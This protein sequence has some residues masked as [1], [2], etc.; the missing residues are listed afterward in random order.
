VKNVVA[1]LRS[2]DFFAGGSILEV[3]A[4]TGH[5]LM[6]G[7]P[8]RADVFFDSSPV[9][10]PQDGFQGTVVAAYPAEGSPL[11][12]GYLLGEQHLQGLGAE[13]VADHGDGHVVLM[14]FRPQWRG[15]PFGTFRA[16]FNSVLFHGQVARAKGTS[17]FWTAPKPAKEAEE[18]P[19]APGGRRN[20]G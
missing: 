18:K 11:M 7:M 4:D 1:G 15:Q 8:E 9:F 2:Q 3:R 16:L 12:S 14:G 13:V 19:V 5:P 17:G 6:A 20:G 10:A